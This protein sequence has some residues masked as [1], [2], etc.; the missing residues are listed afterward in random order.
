MYIHTHRLCNSLCNLKI[1][2]KFNVGLLQNIK[3]IV[4]VNWFSNVIVMKMQD[5]VIVHWTTSTLELFEAEE[6]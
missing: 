2:T 5:Y 3:I 1:K 6:K 4:S